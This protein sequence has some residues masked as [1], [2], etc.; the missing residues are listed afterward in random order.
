M[1]D[2]GKCAPESVATLK[3]QQDQL[4]R[5]KRPVQMFPIGTEELKLPVGFERHANERGVFHFNPALI[6]KGDVD[7]LSL[8]GKE[9]TFLNLGPYNKEDV[10]RR[11]IM[12][13]KLTYVTEFAIDD[14]EIRCAVVSTGTA[15]E[16]LSYFEKTKEPGSRITIGVLPNRV[17]SHLQKVK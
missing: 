7:S 9:N 8:N 11:T 16:V 1:Y 4:I 12:G 3:L 17:I 13:E 15:K 14:I 10:L 5:G 2:T 6:N